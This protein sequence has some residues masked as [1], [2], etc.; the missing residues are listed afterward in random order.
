MT[1]FA[2]RR[3]RARELPFRARS[4]Q[5][6][7]TAI[8]WERRPN[9]GTTYRLIPRVANTDFDRIAAAKIQEHLAYL[10]RLAVEGIVP[11]NLANKAR[12]VWYLVLFSTPEHL[13]VPAAS[14][15]Q[16][17]P[18]EY[19]WSAGP[20]QLLVEIPPDGLCHWTYKNKTSGELWGVETPADD[21]LPNRL[22]RILSQ[23]A[24]AAK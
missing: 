14:A 6:E 9:S 20:H 2:H 3:L 17:G 5:D 19:H 22:E 13:P 1:T 12:V 21:K 4:R 18:I 11:G 24:I 8:K 16:G 7:T 23:V 10:R 15:F